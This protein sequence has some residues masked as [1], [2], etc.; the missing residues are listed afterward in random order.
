VF[1]RAAEN[2]YRLELSGGYYA[3][4][5]RADKQFRRSLKIKNR[6]L[7][8]GRLAELRAQG[9]SLTIDDDSRLPSDVIAQRWKQ[10]STR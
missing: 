1:H 2:P 8:D 10:L 3:L 6:K 5:K 4:F 9:G 7:A